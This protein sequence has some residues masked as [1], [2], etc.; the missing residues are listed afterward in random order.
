MRTSKNAT[1]TRSVKNMY[2]PNL[3]YFRQ[4]VVALLSVHFK[5]TD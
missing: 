3:F 2:F 5:N 1:K 4:N